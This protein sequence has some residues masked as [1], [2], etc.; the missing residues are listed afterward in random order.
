MACKDA[1]VC[2]RTKNM[3]GIEPS[4][5]ATMPWIRRVQQLTCARFGVDGEWECHRIPHKQYQPGP[6]KNGVYMCIVCDES[7]T[8]FTTKARG[9]ARGLGY[10]HEKGI[11]RSDLKG[12]STIF[13]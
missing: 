7:S 10:L 2:K 1:L 9:I 3:D 4:Q 11:V 8:D 12:V 13:C 6:V 5:R